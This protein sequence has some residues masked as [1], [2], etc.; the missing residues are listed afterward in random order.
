VS[1][2]RISAPTVQG[3]SVTSSIRTNSKLKYLEI[4]QV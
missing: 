4:Y 1:G 2:V 3:S